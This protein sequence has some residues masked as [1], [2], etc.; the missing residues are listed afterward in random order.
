MFFS[1]WPNRTSVFGG[2]F[3]GDLLCMEA[4]STL[5]IRNSSFSVEISLEI[6]VFEKCK[7][8]GN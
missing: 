4:I 2:K 8:V 6:R 3:T 1:I 5:M 7:L